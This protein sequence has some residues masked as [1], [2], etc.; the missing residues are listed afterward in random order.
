MSG[1]RALQYALLAFVFIQLVS[2]GSADNGIAQQRVVEWAEQRLIF[3]ADSRMGQVRSF[4][5]GNGAPVPYARTQGSLRKSVLDLQLDVQAG[6]L[7]VLGDDGV[8]V[9]DA[10]R[11]ALQQNIPLE[12]GTVSAL[13]FADGYVLLLSGSG[14]QIGQIDCVTRVARWR[15]PVRRG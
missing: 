5:L 6:H 10:R 3:V 2:C 15:N 13:G 4:F 9:Y 11:L 8:S 12:T 1:H 14:E 7:W